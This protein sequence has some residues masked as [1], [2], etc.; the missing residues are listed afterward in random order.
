MAGNNSLQVLR[1]S[2]GSLSN[3][4]LLSGQPLYDKT[5]QVL[6]IGNGSGS[7]P[8]SKLYVHGV[9]NTAVTIGDD[10]A[11]AYTVNLNPGSTIKFNKLYLPSS[12]NGTSYTTGSSGKVLKTNGTTVYWG[13][14]NN[15]TYSIADF[16][17]SGLIKPAYSSTGAVT[18]TTSAA[19]NAETPTINARTTT[20]GRYYAT[21]I[22]KNGR[23]Y[24]NVPW[25]NYYQNRDYSSGLKIATGVGINNLYVPTATNQQQGA[26][27]VWRTTDCTSY[28]NDTS[29]IT[30]A[31]V[32]KAVGKFVQI[33]P[34]LTS[35]TK[36]ATI[37]L[38]DETNQG[39]SNKTIDLYC[40]TNTHHTAYN[41]I[42]A[43]NT[44]ANAA[45]TNGNTYL[46]LYENGNKRSQFKINGTGITTVSSDA[47]GNI[48]INSP[49]TN[50]HYITKLYATTSSGTANASTANGNT[51]LRL[52][53]DT[54]ARSSIKI[55]GTGASSVSSDAN[56]VITISSTNSAHAH[57]AG[58]GLT[59]SGAGGTS[60]TVTYS[61]N[62]KNTIS[63]GTIGTTSKL[64]AIGVDSN[65]Q[66][67]VN[68][69]WTDDDTKVTQAATA[70][71]SSSSY[72]LTYSNSTSTSAVTSSVRRSAKLKYTPST[73]TLV[74]GTSGTADSGNVTVYGAVTINSAKITYT[75]SDRSINFLFL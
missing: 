49:D 8:D 30:P 67:C 74:V 47:N 21:E 20:E 68:V 58:T 64:Y 66:L 46:K 40:Q 72:A 10:T 75:S 61:A 73:G 51:Y 56:G 53:D 19:T 5:D 32:K 14:D 33:S 36:I 31:A 62:L 4:N 50:T 23:L 63:L 28:T 71:T 6:Y 41:Y 48:T 27:I 15:T 24:V 52:F 45:T 60:G 29:A 34:S 26:T 70:D 59:I 25:V 38:P 44:A 37:T 57:T 22:D 65:G 7:L 54:T 16:D 35:G 11:T 42:G 9:K 17:T 39:T 3:I 13:T 12:S 1:G 43:A 55:T 69:P 2:S 18:L